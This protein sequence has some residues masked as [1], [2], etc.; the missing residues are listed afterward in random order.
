MNKKPAR[1]IQLARETVRTLTK[2]QLSDVAG[3]TDGP[4]TS[5]WVTTGPFPSRAA[6]TLPV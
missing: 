2:E 1:K 4:T 3:G 6:C 5:L